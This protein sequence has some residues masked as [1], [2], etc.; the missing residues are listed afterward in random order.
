M[1][2]IA[3]LLILATSA[4]AGDIVGPVYDK[5]CKEQNKP[6]WV[7][8]D[9]RYNEDGKP[10]DLVFCGHPF[11]DNDS[12]DRYVKYTRDK[13]EKWKKMDHDEPLLPSPE[14]CMAT[15]GGYVALMAR[16]SHNTG[17]F[18]VEYTAESCCMWRERCEDVRD[19]QGR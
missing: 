8:K 3:I 17:V 9:A 6:A 18:R 1:R 2:T 5:H 13:G 19:H 14:G 10:Y 16:K 15:S 12:W 4:L 7:E 11:D